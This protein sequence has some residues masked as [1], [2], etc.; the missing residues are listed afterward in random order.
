M[1]N[2]SVIVIFA[3]AV[4]AV[5]TVPSYAS[6]VPM[7]WG[8]PTQVQNSSLTTFGN[9]FAQ[10]NDYELSN[11]SFPTNTTSAVSSS[12]PTITQISNQSQIASQLN[13]GSQQQSS[14]FAYPWLSVGD[15]PVPSMGSI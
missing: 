9:D 11:I 7:S 3:L 15:S 4:V 2:K 1:I 5:M 10:S 8:F 6:L 14:Y 13:F 12:F